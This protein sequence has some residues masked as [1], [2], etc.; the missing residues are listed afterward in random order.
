[1]NNEVQERILKQLEAVR[2]SNSDISYTAND[3]GS[4]SV[5]AEGGGQAVILTD[6]VVRNRDYKAQADIY[7]QYLDTHKDSCNGAVKETL[8]RDI[9]IYDFLA[10]CSQKDTQALIDTGV[11]NPYIMAYCRM[12]ARDAG[13]DEQQKE[14]LVEALRWLLDTR[15]S[16]EIDAE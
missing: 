14:A 9:R 4:I 1:M 6:T 3:D 11:Y 8:E 15:T 10:T 13:L 2:E 7:R 16:A 12:A 5:Q